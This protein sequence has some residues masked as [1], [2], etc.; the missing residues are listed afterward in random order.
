MEIIEIIGFLCIA[1]GLYFLLFDKHP[2]QEEEE[3]ET[4]LRDIK[5]SKSMKLLVIDNRA[6]N[7]GLIIL[8]VLMLIA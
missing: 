4:A 3:L 1:A 7:V 8:G 6:V 2:T 5:Q